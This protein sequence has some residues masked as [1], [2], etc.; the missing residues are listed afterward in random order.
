MQNRTLRVAL[1]VIFVGLLAAPYAIKHW[2][3][4]GASDA[5]LEREAALDRYGFVLGQVAQRA[6]VDFVHQ[7]PA[8]DDKLAHIMPEV[9]A[10]GAGVSVADF[11]RDG[12]PDFYT[13]N[14]AYGSQNALYRNNGDGT[15]TDVAADLGVAAL[16]QPG[17]G[18]SMG[19]VWGDYNNDGYEDL[20]LYKWGQ[21][22]LFRND[23]GA[24]FTRVTDRLNGLP[25]WINANTA[26]WFD[27]NNDGHLDLFVGGFYQAG[28]DLW[29]LETA[30]VMPES[31]EYAQNGGRNYL[32]RNEGDGSFTEIGAEMGF[33]STRWT[34]S[35]DVFDLNGDGY[36]D[37]FVA[38]DYGIDE[39]YLNEGGTR[40]REIGRASNISRTPKSGMNATFGDV[41]NQGA[42][43]LYV[44]NIAEDGVLIQ[45][46]N[47]WV[48]RSG[49]GET[50]V[51]DDIATAMGVDLAGWSYGAQFGDLNNDGW[52]DLF[53]TNGYVSGETRESYWYDFSKVA[54]G[55]ESI[56][57]DAANWPAMEGRS[58]S[59]YQQS[60]VW[61]NDGA[62]NFQDVAQAVGGAST[63]DG[64]A[65]AL[66]D[67][68]GDGSLDVLVAHQR[69][70]LHIYRSEAAPDHHWIRFELE[71][72]V[73]NRSAIGAR[74]HLYWDGQEQVQR[75]SGGSGF[76]AQ[77]Q[78]ALHFGLGKAPSVEKAVVHWP[79]GETQTLA[80]PAINTTH[81]LQ[82]PR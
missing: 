12:D 77:N 15:F 14:S 62:G 50:P 54:G 3:D 55:N 71:G 63:L 33:E 38:N 67:L 53:V 48:P 2:S 51:F 59:G 27:Y 13:T 30:R 19:S 52:L 35:A 47:L 10:M 17:T 9:A 37:L 80:T 72:T 23:Q 7:P 75:V 4:A 42:P 1:S 56:I 8:L 66:A 11:D 29:N 5:Q 73:S 24:G 44:S 76:S 82:E 60:R 20:F 21:V 81:T 68:F 74:V 31:Y 18:T 26:I 16:N 45:G 6:G 65:V 69:G 64:R 46:N 43:A 39:L 41:L 58:L 78:R 32:F 57:A 79:S 70:P 36:E 22:Q 34:L 61:L 25:N 28:L 40:F 49:P